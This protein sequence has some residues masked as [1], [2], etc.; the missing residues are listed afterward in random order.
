M[1]RPLPDRDKRQKT[2]LRTLLSGQPVIRACEASGLRWSTVYQWRKDNV[3]FRAAW[4]AAAKLGIE[5]MAARF[6][7]AL[8]ERAVDGVDEPVFKGGEQ[9]GTRRRYSDALLMFGIQDMRERLRPPPRPPGSAL[10]PQDG[11]RRITVVVREFGPPPEKG[12]P[13]K[14]ATA[15]TKPP[16]LPVGEKERGDE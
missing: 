11:N 4:D 3:A 7:A 14:V 8:V 16:A 10:G 1:A 9:V 13:E 5:A 15:E 2:F 6:D 12:A